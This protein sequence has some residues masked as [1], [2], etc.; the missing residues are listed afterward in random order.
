MS[1][2]GKQNQL[3]GFSLIEL[4][5]VLGVISVLAAFLIFPMMRN[6]LEN[7]KSARCLTNLRQIGVA[8]EVYIGENNQRLPPISPVGN[9]QQFFQEAMARYV[10]LALPFPFPANHSREAIGVFCCPGDKSEV[11]SAYRSYA[12]NYYTG[13]SADFTYRNIA[14]RSECP[15]PSKI[16]YLADGYRSD[17]P[18][19][20]KAA[21]RLSPN[22]TGF[23]EQ[24]R[25][26]G[27][28]FRHAE[29]AHALWL[30]GHVSPLTKELTLNN[31]AILYPLD[32]R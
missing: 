19:I 14:R 21:S 29:K 10:N 31:S 17:G 23:S 9:T 3:R 7:G 27:L 22:T 12:I 5:V 24:P 6:V 25:T 15:A 13:P 2:P 16:V 32:A 11:L 30:D 28:S 1:F 4:L 8:L 18:T 26:I 20:E